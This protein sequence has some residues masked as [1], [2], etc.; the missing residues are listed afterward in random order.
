M[1]LYLFA[2]HETEGFNIF[3][4]AFIDKVLLPYCM[5]RQ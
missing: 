1:G 3:F 4:I 5:I 2:L